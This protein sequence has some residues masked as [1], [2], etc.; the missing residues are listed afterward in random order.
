MIKWL[1]NYK[2]EEMAYSSTASLEC[3]TENID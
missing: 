3:I 1:A 2:G